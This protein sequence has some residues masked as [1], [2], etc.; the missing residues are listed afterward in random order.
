M[1]RDKELAEKSK[2]EQAV[3]LQGEALLMKCDAYRKKVADELLLQKAEHDKT[4]QEILER[5]ERITCQAK[6]QE[7]WMRQ[8]SWR[9]AERTVHSK[10][11]EFA[12]IDLTLFL[13][14]L[15]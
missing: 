2:R 13:T 9:E 8:R 1:A 11:G 5:S 3:I 7:Q 10:Q 6:L 12:I 15:N 14:I 4:E